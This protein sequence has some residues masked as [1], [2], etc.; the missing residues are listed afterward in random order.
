MSHEDGRTEHSHNR[1]AMK[2]KAFSIL[3]SLVALSIL[4]FV[5]AS[6]L[7]TIGFL[8][9]SSQVDMGEVYAS[10]KVAESEEGRTTKTWEFRTCIVER[11]CR[12]YST[13]TDV[14]TL[15]A[16]QPSGRAILEIRKIIPHE[17]P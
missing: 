1:S 8:Y 7:Y 13:E 15:T 12:E 2:L 3:E 14:C 4:A 16:R 17:T 6:S 9:A 10:I 5:T 11:E